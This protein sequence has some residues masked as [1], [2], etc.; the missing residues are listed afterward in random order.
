MPCYRVLSHNCATMNIDIVSSQR[1]T[2]RLAIVSLCGCVALGAC[3][4]A[5]AVDTAAVRSTPASC[6]TL[7]ALALPA[8]K[9][10]KVERVEAGA[11]S[12]PLCPRGPPEVG[13]LQHAA[14]LL[15]RGGDRRADA[16][17]RDQ[18]RSVAAGRRVERQVRGG[19][20]RRFQRR[21][22]ATSTWPSHCG[23]AM[24]WPAATPATKAAPP[25]P[26]SPSDT[27]RSSWTSRGARCTRRR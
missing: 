12:R 23:A 20:Q 2:G 17:L 27:L 19:R 24:R 14:C 4:R 18:V 8:T 5:A 7:A 22:F 13:R 11:L 25:T 15:P 3:N 21:H 10:T 6:E 16:G 26:A 9:V 1:L